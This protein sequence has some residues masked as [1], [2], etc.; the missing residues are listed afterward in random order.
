MN[1]V[2]VIEIIL[3]L[4]KYNLIF[5]VCCTCPAEGK[6][7]SHIL[8]LLMSV[9]CLPLE[10]SH[11]RYFHFTSPLMG[12]GLNCIRRDCKI[13]QYP[14]DKAL[15]WNAAAYFLCARRRG[16]KPQRVGNPGQAGATEAHHDVYQ[17]FALRSC[18]ELISSPDSQAEVRATWATSTSNQSS[19]THQMHSNHLQKAAFTCIPPVA[20]APDF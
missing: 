10:Q 2:A 17:A 20:C 3:I 6:F 8:V 4:F 16:C 13:N 11:S 19:Q 18:L 12:A 7:R 5:A 14:G 1:G 9:A 15:C